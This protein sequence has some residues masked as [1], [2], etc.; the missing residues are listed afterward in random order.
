MTERNSTQELLYTNYTD[1]ELFPISVGKYVL[2]HKSKSKV[3]DLCFEVINNNTL[4]KNGKSK[5][6]YHI[7]NTSDENLLDL[8]NFKWF[9]KIIT[10]LSCEYI[11][12]VLGYELK[13]GIVITDCWLN[14]CHSNGDQFMH[15]HSNSFVSGTYYVNFDPNVHGKLTFQHVHMMPGMNSSPFIEL[16][17]KKI[18]S[19][20]LA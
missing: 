7:Y 12:N 5:N 14:V 4:L 15:N 1:L 6:L 9:E 19:I 17:I 18:L 20:I 3:K 11:E 10:K 16:N 2:D 8:D 13:D